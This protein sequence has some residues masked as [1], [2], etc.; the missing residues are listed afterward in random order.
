M[1]FSVITDAQWTL[2][3][4]RHKSHVNTSMDGATSQKK[5]LGPLGDLEIVAQQEETGFQCLFSPLC[6][7][8]DGLR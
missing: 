2:V 6:S 5:P 4:D 7:T 8:V 3:A 1:H